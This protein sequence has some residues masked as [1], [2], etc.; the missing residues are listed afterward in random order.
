[1]RS[2]SNPGC[3]AYAPVCPRKTTGSWD[4][5]ETAA[6]KRAKA[7][8]KDPNEELERRVAERTN[9]L[10]FAS[11]ALREAQRELAH[12]NRVTTMGRLTA[13]IIVA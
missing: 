7:E 5:V 4:V 3:G 9:Q 1:M 13:S 6:L 2:F 11:E 8:L 12:V 10:M